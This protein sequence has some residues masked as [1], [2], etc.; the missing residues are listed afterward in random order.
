MHKMKRS[1]SEALKKESA[2]NDNG[3]EIKD[4]IDYK[5]WSEHL[6]MQNT[7]AFRIQKKKQ[8]PSNAGDEMNSLT[9][10]TSDN[11]RQ[12]S[13]VV[14]FIFFFQFVLCSNWLFLFSFVRSLSLVLS[15]SLFLL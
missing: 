6:S 13:Q 10:Q 14:V 1:W 7:V 11:A 8:T 2:H 12:Q 4:I 3:S 5:R 15:S 9:L